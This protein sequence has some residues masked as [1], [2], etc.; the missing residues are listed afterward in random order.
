MRAIDFRHPV[1]F[2]TLFFQQTKAHLDFPGLLC[3]PS[4]T[5]LLFERF[6]L[7][8]Q[9]VPCSLLHP[10][11]DHALR[12]LFLFSGQYLQ[13]QGHTAQKHVNLYLTKRE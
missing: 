10:F 8:K 13:L 3:L 4:R 5:K 12:L 6:S 7:Y 1:L 9:R 2:F 11:S